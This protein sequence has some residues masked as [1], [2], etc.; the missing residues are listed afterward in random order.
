MAKMQGVGLGLAALRPL[1]PP[2]RHMFMP[3]MHHSQSIMLQDFGIPQMVSEYIAA[4]A[5][6]ASKSSC[7]HSWRVGRS[8]NNPKATAFTPTPSSKLLGARAAHA[9]RPPVPPPEHPHALKLGTQ[10]GDVCEWQMLANGKTAH[11]AEP[12]QASAAAAAGVTTTA[13]AAASA[14][15]A[16]STAT[17]AARHVAVASLR[18]FLM[19]QSQH[20]FPVSEG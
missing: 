5:L 14:T 3:G 2:P 13:A 8:R 7:E 16:T 9:P 1:K 20:H 11:F 6:E 17:A 10:P 12:S 4:Q 19:V 15:T 18:F